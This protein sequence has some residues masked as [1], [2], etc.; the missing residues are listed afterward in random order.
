[1]TSK[2]YF[3]LIFFSSGLLPMKITNK[4]NQQKISFE[5]VPFPE[6]PPKTY[7]LL[8]FISFI[9]LLVIR[10]VEKY[11]RHDH[12][13]VSCPDHFRTC[14]HGCLTVIVSP[15][16]TKDGVTFVCTSQEWTW[17]GF[18]VHRVTT[19]FGRRDCLPKVPTLQTPL[20]RPLPAI[21]HSR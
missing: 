9:V 15:T 17:I 16:T 6:Y 3:L 10:R 11:I 8:I 18:R 5:V 4:K 1:M 7:I 2:T 13:S 12:N 19:H 20:A 21:V 14:Q